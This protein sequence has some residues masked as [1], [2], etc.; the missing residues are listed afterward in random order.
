ME[1]SWPLTVITVMRPVLA[2]AEPISL[3]LKVI[4]VAVEP[5]GVTTLFLQNFTVRPFAPKPVPLIVKMPPLPNERSVVE[6]L[7]IDGGVVVSTEYEVAPLR[8][9]VEPLPTCPDGWLLRKTI[10]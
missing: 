4:V 5:E 6:R 1:K 3:T 8:A 2:P 10:K 7:V 9:I